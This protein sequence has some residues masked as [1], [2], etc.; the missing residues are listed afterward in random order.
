MTLTAEELVVVETVISRHGR[1]DKLQD[2]VQRQTG[3][4][5]TRHKVIFLYLTQLLL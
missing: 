5:C 1:P 3:V 4:M 2:T